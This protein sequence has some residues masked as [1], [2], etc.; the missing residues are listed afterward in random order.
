MAEDSVVD[1]ESVHV[2]MKKHRCISGRL[3]HKDSGGSLR[4]KFPRNWWFFIIKIT[5]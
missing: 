5:L 3:S 4:T 1:G 2:S